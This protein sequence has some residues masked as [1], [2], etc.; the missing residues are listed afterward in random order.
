M[1]ASRPTEI[2]SERVQ[3]ADVY[4][5]GLIVQLLSDRSQTDG[6]VNGEVQKNDCTKYSITSASVRKIFH[7]SINCLFSPLALHEHIHTVRRFSALRFYSSYLNFAS[8]L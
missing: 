6:P 7:C 4:A 8:I 5:D 3:K 2:L 1:F